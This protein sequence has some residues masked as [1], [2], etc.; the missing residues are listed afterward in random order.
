MKTRE[1]KI[2]SLK[3]DHFTR[4]HKKLAFLFVLRICHQGLFS[5]SSSSS[6]K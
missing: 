1:K 2:N 5:S 6:F 4:T 3:F